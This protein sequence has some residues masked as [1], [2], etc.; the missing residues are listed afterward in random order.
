[1]RRYL[2][3]A[4]SLRRGLLL[5][6]SVLCL[7][8]AVRGQGSSNPLNGIYTVT[9]VEPGDSPKL[10]RGQFIINENTFT[11]ECEYLVDVV[12]GGKRFELRHCFT[13]MVSFDPKRSPNEVKFFDSATKKLVLEGVYE[14]NDDSLRLCLVPLGNPLPT[15]VAPDKE[16]KQTVISLRR[17]GGVNEARPP[18]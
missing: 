8:L 14:S 11:R 15:E 12:G 7:A 18:Q 1:M 13:A 9:A 2:R 6:T 17:Y 3:C 16:K 5:T 4:A 10:D